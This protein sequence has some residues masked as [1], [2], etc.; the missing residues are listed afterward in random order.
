MKLNNPALKE[1][2]ASGKDTDSAKIPI[3]ERVMTK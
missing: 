3:H 2:M 1:L